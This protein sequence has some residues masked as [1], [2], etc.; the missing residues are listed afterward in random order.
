MDVQGDGVTE[1]CVS[2]FRIGIAAMLQ[3]N[4][5]LES[6]SIQSRGIIEIKVEGYFVLVTARSNTIQRS[7]PSTFF[8]NSQFG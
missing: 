8:A 7:N 1:S 5:L 6:I 4:T 3:E 2:A